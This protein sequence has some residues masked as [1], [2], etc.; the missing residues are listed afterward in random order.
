MTG[1]G[2][3]STELHY[4]IDEEDSGAGVDEVRL[5][6]TVGVGAKVF[7]PSRSL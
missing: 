1:E 6:S 5:E 3:E 2:N 7:S 4:L